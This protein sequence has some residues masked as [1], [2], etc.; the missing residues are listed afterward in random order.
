MSRA[1]A[2]I[3]PALALKH[4]A[5]ALGGITF[6]DEL[7]AG[8]FEGGADISKRALVG[9]PSFILKLCQGGA[10]DLGLFA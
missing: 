10:P 1:T 3:R 5:A 8:G 9:H 2:Q 7:D 4:H 6:T